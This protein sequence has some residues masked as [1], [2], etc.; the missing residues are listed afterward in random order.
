VNLRVSGVEFRVEG[1]KPKGVRGESEGGGRTGVFKN[2]VWL[3]SWAKRV[4]Q[5]RSRGAPSP[6]PLSL[7][8]TTLRRLRPDRS[9]P[10]MP[11]CGCMRALRRWRVTVRL[12]GKLSLASPSPPGITHHIP[13]GDFFFV[14]IQEEKSK[15]T[16]FEAKRQDFDRSTFGLNCLLP[17]LPP[18][19]TYLDA[20]SVVVAT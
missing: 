12:R 11:T 19:T 14:L 10:A 5:R 20:P 8:P 7:T 3:H 18:P 1:C 6:L 2:I 9:C 17:L 16:N 15:L 13:S 4:L